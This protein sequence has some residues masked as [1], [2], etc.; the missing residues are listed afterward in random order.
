[1]FVECNAVECVGILTITVNQAPR[2][3][4]ENNIPSDCICQTYPALI[5]RN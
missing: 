2:V 1:M 5:S 4:L 3:F